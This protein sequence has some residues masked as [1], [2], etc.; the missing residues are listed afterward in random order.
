MPLLSKAPE[1]KSGPVSREAP[2]VREAVFARI[3]FRMGS[4]Q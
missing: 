2:P 4:N 1:R 3:I